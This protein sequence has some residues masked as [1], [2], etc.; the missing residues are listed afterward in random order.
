M[1]EGAGLGASPGQHVVE[2]F[3]IDIPVGMVIGRGQPAS[4]HRSAL[5][6]LRLCKYRLISADRVLD[7]KVDFDAVHA[8]EGI[9]DNRVQHRI[10]IRQELVECLAHIGA[11]PVAEFPAAEPDEVG[12]NQ[13]QVIDLGRPDMP[14]QLRESRRQ[15]I[16]GC[17][18]QGRKQ[19]EQLANSQGLKL[20][21]PIVEAGNAGG[22]VIPAPIMLDALKKLLQV[23]CPGM[24][25][26]SI[27]GTERGRTPCKPE[28]RM[29]LAQP[30]GL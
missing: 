21:K 1:L 26:H 22:A 28:L 5:R 4:C 15:F 10:F 14:K 9:N 25:V 12:D 16:V 29:G 6:C 13:A 3:P 18:T 23:P 17:L 19:Q 20:I 8:F 2:G 30:F 24:M 27:Y 7:R 11:V